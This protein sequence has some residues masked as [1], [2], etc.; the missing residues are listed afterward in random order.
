MAQAA[1]ILAYGI[2]HWDGGFR[3]TSF[4]AVTPKKTGKD[5]FQGSAA[6]DQRNRICIVV[7]D[8]CITRTHCRIPALHTGICTPPHLSSG[9]P[10]TIPFL[11][12]CSFCLH[13]SHIFQG[14]S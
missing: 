6:L 5:G 8:I 14:Y 2:N 10:E 9:V 7:H 3:S 4:L 11:L 1:G 13:R 12:W